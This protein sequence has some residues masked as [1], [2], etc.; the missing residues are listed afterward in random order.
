M[1]A[2]TKEVEDFIVA[3][4]ETQT[5]NLQSGQYDFNVRLPG[6]GETADVN[7]LEL[8]WLHTF[9]NGFG[10]QANATVVNSD[11]SLDASDTT[12]VFAL[13]GL[14]DSQNLILFYEQGP[15][16]ARVAYNNREAFMQDLVS[17][18]GGTEPRFTKT[19]G[20]VDVSASYDINESF[21]VF[22]EGINVT[23]ETLS[24][25]GRYEEQFVQLID[26]GARYTL[27]VRTS[28]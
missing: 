11:A 26:D 23:G 19:Y 20:Q 16:Q 28:F 12:Q 6:N 10:I 3:T 27:G 15:L 4:V 1:A 7:G 2:F 18:L 14:G 21:T 25:H 8:A 17:P 5:L 22:F 13:E 24:R 9:E